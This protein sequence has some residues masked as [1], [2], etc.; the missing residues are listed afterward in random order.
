MHAK[1][2]FFSGHV[3]PRQLPAVNPFVDE[4]LEWFYRFAASGGIPAS[5]FGPDYSSLSGHSPPKPLTI[6]I[7]SH[8]W[9]YANILSYQLS[10]LVLFPPR[11]TNICMTVFFSPED[12]RTVEVLNHFRKLELNRV[13]WN[14]WPLD[15]AYL[16]RRAIGRNLAALQSRADWVFF[17]DCDLLFREDSLEQL[18]RVL[19]GE[20][21]LL[22]FPRHHQVSELLPNEDPLFTDYTRA[23]IIR[24]IA[25]E[26]FYREERDRAVG[27]FQI[28]RGDAARFGGYCQNITYYH[29]P[30]KRWRK[31]Y[32]DRT[33]RWLL[34]T[35]GKPLDVPGFYRIR[36]AV[37]GRK[38]KAV[39]GS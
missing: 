1:P 33:I 16:C 19:Q 2:D 15:K 26:R 17:T 28:M 13:R 29:R 34:Q 24:D 9:N 39:G 11:D 12:K 22:V 8:C 35:Q 5:W 21:S 10:S 23:G 27:G 4:L 3:P 6:E 32:E 18:S 25:P 30:V 20:H 38:G 37:K 31:C 14:F 7:V 36:H